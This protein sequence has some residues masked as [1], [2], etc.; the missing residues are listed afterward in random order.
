LRFIGGF[1]AIHWIPAAS[2]APVPNQLAEQES[3]IVTHMNTEHAQ[4]LRDFFG[5]QP[6]AG[7]NEVAMV[8]IDCDGFDVRA[9]GEL[10]RLAFDEPVANAAD[11]RRAL[12][13]M[14]KQA[15]AL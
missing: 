11:A 4:S 2:Y 3:E 6:Q 13:A 10:L 7:A 5:H 9:D 8:G 1:G 12:V 14:A 15:H